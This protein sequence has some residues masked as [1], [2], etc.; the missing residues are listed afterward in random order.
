MLESQQSQEN[1]SKLID[2]L[3]K[4][5]R[6]KLKNKL[7]ELMHLEGGAVS[8]G[9]GHQ[10]VCGR[11]TGWTEIVDCGNR[12]QAEATSGFEVELYEAQRLLQ[13]GSVLLL[14]ARKAAGEWRTGSLMCQVSFEMGTREMPPQQR[15]RDISGGIVRPW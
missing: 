4:D 1:C 12:E 9:K 13:R 3:T 8:V 2:Q 14:E 6:I 15:L 10:G 7:W 11:H 5:L